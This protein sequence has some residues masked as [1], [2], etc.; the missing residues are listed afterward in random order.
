MST[1]FGMSV[2]TGINHSGVFYLWLDTPF[3]NVLEF[4]E[5]PFVP[6]KPKKELPDLLRF[7]GLP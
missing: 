5:I 7:L 1:Q 3:F 2:Y 4:G 6:K